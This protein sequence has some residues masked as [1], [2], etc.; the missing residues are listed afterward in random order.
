MSKFKKAIAVFAASAAMMGAQV[1]SASTYSPTGTWD[2]GGSAALGTVL[3]Q[4]G[5]GP[6]LACVGTANGFTASTNS[7]DG[8]TSISITAGD[9]GC[10]TIFIQSSNPHLVDKPNGDGLGK[11]YIIKNVY[12]NTTITPGDCV[13]DI[14]TTLSQD[15]GGPYLDVNATLAPGTPGTGAC[16]IVGKLYLASPAGGNIT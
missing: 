14:E 6:L 16:T 12:V 2:F 7:L 9:A 15:A 3:V 8:P 13:G 5:S 1:A 11:Q 10:V 4:K